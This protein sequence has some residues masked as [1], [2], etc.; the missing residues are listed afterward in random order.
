[1]RRSRRDGNVLIV[2]LGVLA[3]AV[4]VVVMSSN[5]LIASVKSNQFANAQLDALNAV[6][7][8]LAIHSETV[9]NLANNGDP[10]A[11]ST[12]GQP[13][14]LIPGSNYGLEY[15]N[16]CKVHWK[17]EPAV[18]VTKDTSG[19]WV[20]F[21]ASPSPDQSWTPPNSLYNGMWQTNNY[22]YLY[23]ISADAEAMDSA[24][25]VL[26]HAQ[27]ASFSSEN[28][29][30]LFRYVIFYVQ[31]G[32]KGDLEF[33]HAGT[34][35][36]AGNVHSNG[37]IYIGAGTDPRTWSGLDPSSQNTIFGAATPATAAVRVEGV[38]GIFCLSKPLLYAGMGNITGGN[39]GTIPMMIDTPPVGTI[40]S[41]AYD[42]TDPKGTFPNDPATLDLT[43][44][45][46]A[47][48]NATWINPYRVLDAGELWTYNG[49]SSSHII[50]GNP[51]Q[52]GSGTQTTTPLP[53]DSRD[54]QRPSARAF[55]SA[56][57]GPNPNGWLGEVRSGLNG[58]GVIPLAKNMQNRPFEAQAL[59]YNTPSDHNN[60]QPLFL[61]SGKPTTVVPTS[62][63]VIEDPG[64]YIQYAIGSGNA[65]TRNSPFTGWTVTTTSGGTAN[66]PGTTVGLTI[67]ERAEPAIQ[68]STGEF[69]IAGGPG[70]SV[71]SAVPSSSPD[72]LP[73]AYGKWMRPVLWPFTSMYISDNAY[74]AI[75]ITFPGPTSA[76]ATVSL[77]SNTGATYTVTMN[78]SGTGTVTINTTSHTITGISVAS[79]GSGY[80]GSSSVTVVISGGNGS[81]A[82]ATAT[83]S[84]GVVSSF[85]VTGGGSGYTSAATA[86]SVTVWEVKSVA[87]NNGGGGY[88]APPSLTVSGGGGSGL[89]GTTT[90]TGGVVTG[91]SITNW[92]T[93]YTSAPTVTS[94]AQSNYITAVNVVTPG[95]GYTTAPPTVSF[96]GGGGSGAAGLAILNSAGGVASVNLTNAGSGY[97]SAPSVSFSAPPAGTTAAGT[98]NLGANGSIIAYTISTPGTV[99]TPTGTGAVATLPAN[100]IGTLGT[101]P[102]YTAPS[103]AIGY[104]VNSLGGIDYLV[105]NGSATTSVPT[106]TG[107]SGYGSNNTATTLGRSWANSVVQINNGGNT[108]NIST[109]ATT[110]WAFYRYGGAVFA[111]CQDNNADNHNRTTSYNDANGFFRGNYRF[112][113]FGNNST[114]TAVFSNPPRAD[115]GTPVG[116][117]GSLFL[118]AKTFQMAQMRISYLSG[119]N[120][121]TNASNGRR[122]GLMLRPFSPDAYTSAGTF[123]DLDTG[124]ADP[125]AIGLN[126]RQPYVAVLYSPERGFFTE[127][128]L[129]TS[130]PYNAQLFYTGTGT[131]GFDQPAS[132]PVTQPNAYTS[133][134]SAQTYHPNNFNANWIVSPSSTQISVGEGLITFDVGGQ[135]YG[136]YN[137]LAD[138]QTAYIY[139]VLT[140]A[141][142]GSTPG[143]ATSPSDSGK[144]FTVFQA[145]GGAAYPTTTNTTVLSTTSIQVTYQANGGYNAN[146]WFPN[147]YGQSAG[148]T[149]GSPGSPVVVPQAS[150]A[151][152][153]HG[154]VWSG[155][156]N[157]NNALAHETAAQLTADLAAAGYTVVAFPTTSTPNL[158]A[159]PTNAF[160]QANYPAVPPP[161]PTI[162]IPIG[163]GNSAPGYQ[164][165]RASTVDVNSYTTGWPS[166]TTS[167]NIKNGRSWWF[168]ATAIPSPITPFTSPMGPVT[169]ASAGT[170]LLGVPMTLCDQ[171][172]GNAFANGFTPPNTYSFSPDM[173]TGNYVPNPPT[174]SSG[175]AYSGTTTVA[176]GNVTNGGSTRWKDDE[177]SSGW[178]SSNTPGASGKYMWLR[179]KVG[180]DGFVYASYYY[181]TANPP[182][183]TTPTQD[184]TNELIETD[185]WWATNGATTKLC[186]LSDIFQSP[187]VPSLSNSRNLL[188]GLAMSSGN[189][190]QMIVGI[191]NI[192]IWNDT[193]NAGTNWSPAWP[194]VSTE[195]TAAKITNSS[196]WEASTSPNLMSR[197]LAS[198]YQVFYGPADITEDFFKY[199]ENAYNNR[200]ATE[201]WFWNAR[202]FWSMSR[203]WNDN[204]PDPTNSGNPISSRSSWIERET[205]STTAQS[206]ANNLANHAN[207]RL[208][209]KVTVLNLNMAAIQS[210]LTSRTFTQATT[211]W[212]NSS[213][214]NGGP[215]AA[216]LA[217]KFNGLFY[218]ARTN[219][220]PFNPM[221]TWS[222][223]NPYNPLLPNNH[224]LQ[225]MGEY[226]NLTSVL[227]GTFNCV[228]NPYPTSTV[229][230][231]ACIKPQD[232]FHGVMISNAANISWGYSGTGDVFGESKTSIVTPNQM[233]VLGDLNTTTHVVTGS[234]TG[235]NKLTPLAI[236]CDSLTL[237]SNAWTFFAY[238]ID[239]LTVNSQSVTGG[240]GILAK[241]T[242]S[243]PVYGGA[244]A[245]SLTTYN[246]AIATNN[247]PTT[248]ASVQEGQGGAFLQTMS[249]IEN[250]SGDTMS[251]TGSLVVM[252]DR[253]YCHS[254]LLD[255]YKW[256]GRSPFGISGYL[257]TAAPDWATSGGVRVT[258][259]GAGSPPVYGP[260]TRNFT[261]QLDLLTQA[262]TPPFT[263]I[264]V[265]ASGLAGWDRIV[266]GSQ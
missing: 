159:G 8:S 19:N 207:R 112:I 11:I 235:T 151:I 63:Q 69:D 16:G 261:F 179:L 89:A 192:A 218:A 222:T 153:V 59:Q 157:W 154:F 77:S 129:V 265:T 145:V 204:D 262:G 139:Q 195:T 263:P 84:G 251:Y 238:Q 7:S 29:T 140:I 135:A 120:A 198:Q 266:G 15:F 181:G 97:T 20:P 250:W 105:F 197:Y 51:I 217:S 52:G 61:V 232:F 72:F 156:S 194:T 134:T 56:A 64:A 167:A 188:V 44:F 42:L 206:S 249:F 43:S 110:N 82:T 108:G 109:G 71:A 104:H 80:H 86:Y 136:F 255:S 94:G 27:G 184:G 264:G 177:P 102:A 95:F 130:Q 245:A 155:T 26:A 172:S 221:N 171:I 150:D 115:L 158:P 92:G 254:F 117:A 189:N 176:G 244:N 178:S 231:A 81:G 88:T 190:S 53:N 152:G 34:V 121:N 68:P 143:F 133:A 224:S 160:I 210:Y 137:N 75:P 85:S 131:S 47:T 248:L 203:W 247:Q 211:R 201:E 199:N 106:G 163:A 148:L 23:M 18:T 45:A 119:G 113:H 83:I 25:N 223:V 36:I 41:G 242:S 21:I 118:D 246:A 114:N 107:G 103:P 87:V 144:P 111:Q 132:L 253:R 2:S 165:A 146:G 175:S 17:I 230:L 259:A 76:S 55:R 193:T 99:Y 174:D 54:I 226:S 123:H 126:A 32:P 166:D 180:S 187:S 28:K 164:I 128:R 96:S 138:Y 252:D 40:P 200:C 233:Y 116:T 58:A 191:D 101:V 70:A 147:S 100:A 22:D 4:A 228:L 5:N 234:Q 39:L 219:R 237:L 6:Q 209:G 127:R 168:G 142:T 74:D 215:G 31:T 212:D 30:P 243:N 24:G 236:M 93:G 205:G 9:S 161:T 149:P 122:M 37:A 183:N 50:N 3:L 124:G 258:G 65:M 196:V 239:G 227:D 216:T 33:S 78:S 46:T 12:Y 73:Y 67:R 79:A 257:N 260:P 214:F 241:Y 66:F 48:S 208:M 62:G 182:T 10:T 240:G 229:P 162:T 14:S 186:L 202:E 49:A 225:T 169:P 35:N 91:V 57:L 13:G 213:T 1:M 256:D 141:P 38:D 125:T 173:W 60:A 90:V 170:S 220:Y 185:N 98:V